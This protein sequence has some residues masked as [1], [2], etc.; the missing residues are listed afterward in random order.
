MS[1]YASNTAEAM[2]HSVMAKAMGFDLCKAGLE[3]LYDFTSNR[4]MVTTR[5]MM[6]TTVLRLAPVTK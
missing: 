6:A 3:I 2:R 4:E 5:W 1:L